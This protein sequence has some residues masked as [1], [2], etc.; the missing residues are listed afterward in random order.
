MTLHEWGLHHG[1]DKAT[2]HKYLDFY[3]ARIGEPQ[4]ILEF[5]VLNGASLKMWR[6]RYNE[7]LVIGFDI[8]KKKPIDG[9]SIY[10]MDCTD[11]KIDFYTEIDLIVD[12]ASHNTIDQIKAFEFWWP[13]VNKGG[14]YIIEDC[15][16]MHYTQYNPTKIDFK[17]WVESLGI[18]HEYFWRV[19]GDESDS[20]TVIFYK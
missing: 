12:D 16:T 1:S 20:G 13:H 10:E 17:A 7:A 4:Y 6:D 18:R 14:H 8:E 3:E 9:V 15:H 19:P 2:A 11:P 5:G